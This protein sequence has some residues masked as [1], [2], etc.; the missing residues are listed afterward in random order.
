[1]LFIHP[2][3]GGLLFLL[4]G[5]WLTFPEAS[6]TLPIAG[7]SVATA[8]LLYGA[9]LLDPSASWYN[10][11][12]KK[13][14]LALPEEDQRA[15]FQ[16]VHGLFCILAAAFLAMMTWVSVALL[17]VVPGL[18]PEQAIV[19]GLVF[20]TGIEGILVWDLVRMV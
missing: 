3:N 5:L 16:Q 4:I 17:G 7:V 6:H 8:T 1:M 9:T 18:G 14:I 10:L 13:A 15:I 20:L 19:V 11:P 2:L 12:H